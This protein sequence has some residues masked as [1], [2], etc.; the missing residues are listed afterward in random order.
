M[1][2]KADLYLRGK[3]GRDSGHDDKESDKGLFGERMEGGRERT[4]TKGLMAAMN[5]LLT[6]SN[7]MHLVWLN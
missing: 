2:K 1:V 6:L 5:V 7:W 4:R 3:I